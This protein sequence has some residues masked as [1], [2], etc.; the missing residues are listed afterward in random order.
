MKRFQLNMEGKQAEKQLDSV[1]RKAVRP[2][3]DAV[4]GGFM[5]RYLTRHEG[6]LESP[7]GNTKIKGKRKHVYGRRIG[8]KLKGKTGGWFAHFFASPARQLKP[9]HK[10]PFFQTFR[11][12]NGTVA[13]DAIDGITKLVQRMA[14]KSFR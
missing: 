8:P 3:Q 2:W 13:A 4:N 6:R 9:K 1:L 11:G 7:F 12:K 14:K 5:Y 10:I